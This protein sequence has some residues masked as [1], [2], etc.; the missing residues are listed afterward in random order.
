MMKIHCRLRELLEERNLTPQELAVTTSVPL[1]RILAYC[2][3]DVD[4]VS[5]K[6]I[7]AILTVLNSDELSDLFDVGKDAPPQSEAAPIYEQ[8]WDTPCPVSPEGK[9][10]WYRDVTASSSIYQEYFC[11]EC[12]HR[13]FFIL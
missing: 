2:N 6:E 1:D 4:Q 11:S 9:H 7:A 5:M 3:E 13:V 10:I 12:K 8:D